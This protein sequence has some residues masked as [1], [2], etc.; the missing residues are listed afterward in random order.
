M[1]KEYVRSISHLEYVSFTSSGSHGFMFEGAIRALEDNLPDF[2]TWTRSLKG[3]AGCSGGA[4]MALIFALAIKREERS[5]IMYYLSD[6]TNVIRCPNLSLMWNDFGIE[7]GTA[8]RKT[9]QDILAIGGLSER[10]TMQDLHRLF[11]IDIVFVAH[12]M[13]NGETIH[14]TAQTTPDLLVCDAVFASCCIPLVFKPVKFK[15]YVLCDGVLSS[16]TPDVFPRDRTLLF[17]IPPDYD[18]DKI[19][20]WRSFLRSILVACLVHQRAHTNEIINSTCCCILSHP[21][22]KSIESIETNVDAETLQTIIHCGYVQGSLFLRRNLASFLYY[23]V[24]ECLE[25]LLILPSFIDQQVIF[26]VEG[27]GE[28][29]VGNESE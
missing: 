27:Y 17:M 15:N 29:D 5:R 23:L 18:C 25:V 13:I 24:K 22:M 10:S 14:L 19:D 3:V 6:V 1:S 8:F 9:I 16:H 7:D 11:R 4:L 12:N 2:E 20:T 21:F 26:P 28:C